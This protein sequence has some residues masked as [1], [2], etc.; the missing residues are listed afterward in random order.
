MTDGP[1]SEADVRVGAD[2]RPRRLPPTPANRG[3]AAVI[4]FAGTGRSH[5][6]P[7]A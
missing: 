6:Q 1:R 4:L 2:C 3:D 5:D 7:L